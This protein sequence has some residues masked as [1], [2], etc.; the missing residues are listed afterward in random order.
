MEAMRFTKSLPRDHLEETLAG[1]LWPTESLPTVV[2]L[3]P[4]QEAVASI[5]G[6]VSGSQIDTDL[7]E[8]LHKA[9]RV[10]H[11]EAAD[12][13]LWEW[14]CVT[15]FPDLVWRRWNQGQIPGA[16][17]LHEAL[18]PSMHPR[19]LCRP[20]L[21]GVSR[22]T[23][24]RLWWTAE[25]LEDYSLAKRALRNPDMFQNIF[26]RFFGIYPAAARAC[27]DRFEGRSEAEIRGA[28]KWLQQCGSTTILEALSE[29]EV[30]AILDEALS[31]S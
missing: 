20:S 14:L 12:P 18:R 13:R 7:V 31:P 29:D 1:G 4:I 25:Q 26:E 27:L 11:R 5:D 21:N 22:N 10:T 16:E 6:Q 24:A 30:A 15:Q 28:S 2:T 8:P 19:F 9:L 3:E 23:L 17:A